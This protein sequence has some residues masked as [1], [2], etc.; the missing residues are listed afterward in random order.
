[1][2]NL[3]VEILKAGLHTIL[4]DTGRNGYQKMGVPLGGA[5][6]KKAAT[7]ANALVGNSKETPV[8]EITLLGPQIRFTQVCFIAL[9]GANINP[10]L[11]NEPINS[12]EVIEVRA[13]S[14]LSF[15]KVEAGCRAYIAI[16]G[17]WEVKKWL[18]SV[19]A[20]S[21]NTDQLTPES[22]LKKGSKISINQHIEK[23]KITDKIFPPAF[24]NTMRVRVMPGPEFEWFS[25]MAIAKFFSSGHTLSQESNRMGCQL[26]TQLPLMENGQEL[27]SSGIVPGTIQVTRNGNPI[28]LLADGQTTGGYP[29]IANIIEDDLD[30]IAQL[31]PGDEVWFSLVE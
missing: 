30:K 28:I 25:N 4:Q 24:S 31:K 21:F 2:E 20:A 22:I 3:E 1:M 9:T 14:I 13:N 15:G 26:K 16:A 12:Y 7:D 27:I 6:D 29:R 18:G 19:S 10:R 17:Q 23:P 8:I 11:N 5:L